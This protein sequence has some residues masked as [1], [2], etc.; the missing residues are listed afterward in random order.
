MQIQPYGEVGQDSY[1]QA[2][3]YIFG[4]LFVPVTGPVCYIFLR[5]KRYNKREY[6]AHSGV[7]GATRK[8]SSD[9]RKR[10]ELPSCALCSACGAGTAPI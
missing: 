5:I 7:S 4:S 1:R 6:Y 8:E 10:N 2:H 9:E 3:V